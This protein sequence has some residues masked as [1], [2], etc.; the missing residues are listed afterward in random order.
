LSHHG[1]KNNITPEFLELVDAEHFLVSSNGDKFKHPDAQAIESVIQG[2]RHTPTLWFNYRSDFTE[3][4]EAAS[5]K[6]GAKYRT[7]YPAPGK[8]GIVVEI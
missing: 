1:S 8:E 7:H 2:A 6:R 3:I 4:W 5:L